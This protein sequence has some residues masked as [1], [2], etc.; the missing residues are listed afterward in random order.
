MVRGLYTAWT[1][2][3]N[4][5]KRLDIISNNLANSATVG[6]KKEGV[7]N[8]SF[9]EVLTMRVRDNSNK[10]GDSS[11]VGT[12]SLGVKLGEVYTD[13]SQGSLRETGNTYDLSMEGNGFFTLSVV[14]KNGNENTRY[15][16]SAQ[17]VMDKE[18]YIVDV[19]G[20]HLVS[21]SGKLQV[22]TDAGKVMIDVDGSV[23]ADGQLVDKLVVKDFE[24]YD[25]LKKYGDTMY[26]AEQGAQEIDAKG[27]VRQGFTEQSNVNVVNEMVNLIAITRAYEANQ[28]VIQSIDGTLELAANSVGKL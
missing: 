28:K 8:Q 20:N 4:E 23:Y 25:Y 2:M 22:P 6:Y 5:Q 7:T 1:G 12:M 14:D 21:E 16:R 27:S 10:A 15:T 24:D 18:R 17:F 9:D 11:M 13:Y 26:S 19:N 3:S